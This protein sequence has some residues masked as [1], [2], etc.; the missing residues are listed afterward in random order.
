MRNE[1]AARAAGGMFDVQHFVM[2]GVL[3]DE[4]WNGRMIH[5]TV[6]QDLVGAGIVTAEFKETPIAAK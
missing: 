5:T 3:G 1:R 4:L 2:E 6:K